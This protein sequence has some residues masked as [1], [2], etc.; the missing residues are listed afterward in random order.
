MN[1]KRPKRD[2]PPKDYVEKEEE[3][4]DDSP[5]YQFDSDDEETLR[6]VGESYDKHK[7]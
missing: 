3:D 2:V 1:V 7:L 5:Q 4:I 6:A